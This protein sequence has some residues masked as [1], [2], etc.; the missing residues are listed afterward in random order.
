MMAVTSQGFLKP[1]IPTYFA[2]NCKSQ[3]EEDD[4][5]NDCDLEVEK[6]RLFFWH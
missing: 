5:F 4:P 1:T 2:C 3:E 6:T